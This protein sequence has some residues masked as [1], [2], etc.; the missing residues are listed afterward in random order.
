M[1][2]QKEREFMK[3]IRRLIHVGLKG[4]LSISL[5]AYLCLS[6]SLV[7]PAVKALPIPPP[8][9]TFTVTALPPLTDWLPFNAVTFPVGFTINGV[10]PDLGSLVPCTLREAVAEANVA[11]GAVLPPAYVRVTFAAPTPNLIYYGPITVGSNVVI[12]GFP[13]AGPVI[14][15]PNPAVLPN[16]LPQIPAGIVWP[17]PLFQVTGNNSEIFGLTIVG[18]GAGVTASISDGIVVNGN[19]NLVDGNTILGCGK[20]AVRISG[21]STAGFGIANQISQNWLGID[22]TNT[23]NPNQYG[24]VVDNGA[25]NN[26]IGISQAPFPPLPGNLISCNDL[27]GI[28]IDSLLGAANPPVAITMIDTNS[29]GT[30][31]TGTIAKPNQLS[32][33][34]DKQGF[35]TVIKNNQ[36]SGNLQDGI[37]L[38]GSQATQ[39]TTWNMVGTDASGML[40]LPN[41]GHGISLINGVVAAMIGPN[42]IISG[43]GGAGISLTGSSTGQNTILQDMIGVDLAMTASLGNGGLPID[44]N[45]DG[46][47][48]NDAGDGDTG[49]NTLL[50]FPVITGVSSTSIS[51][52]VCSGCEV[53]LYQAMN[54]P[55]KNG[56]GGFYLSKVTA[57]GTSWTATLPAGLTLWDLTFIAYDPSTG[58]T[59]EMSPRGYLFIPM[60]FYP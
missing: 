5:A 8:A 9:A 19:G 23:C 2:H 3:S 22:S 12:Q 29:M 13:L 34:Y 57:S 53:H 10:C 14:T 16:P 7:E 15:V 25:T 21:S 46:H 32:G 20:A 59:S 35:T 50:N 40:A 55:S 33:I 60:L 48:P 58:N 52:T 47:T 39:I 18:Q 42:N 51:G 44:L 45:N 31:S 1:N 17:Y 11:A 56:G 41:G 4:L 37:T 6:P 54:D 43:N 30:D 49:P 28:Y 38:D 24:V 27:H 36:I 26:I